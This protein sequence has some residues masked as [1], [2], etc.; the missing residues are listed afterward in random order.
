MT[1]QNLIEEYKESNQSG[2]FE[3]K[4][5]EIINDII[6]KNEV[7][8]S[9]GIYIIYSIKNLSKNIIYIGKSGTMINDGTFKSQGIAKRLT[10]IQNGLQRRIYFQNVIEKY[11][12]EK[13]EFLWITTFDKMYKEIP[14]LSEAKMIQAYFSEFKKLPLLSKEA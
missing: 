13:L 8:N 4:K 2:I 14:S 9:Y 7:P 12:F 11:Q 10:R 6:R 5:D 1:I 3:L